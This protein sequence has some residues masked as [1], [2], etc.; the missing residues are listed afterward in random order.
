DDKLRHETLTVTA[1]AA[2][3]LREDFFQEAFAHA[4][5]GMAVTDLAGRFLQVNP[6]FCAI[7]GYSQAELLAAD[8]VAITH[9]DDR[10]GNLLLNRQLLAGDI[11]SFDL[12]KRYVKKNGATVWVLVSVS[13]RRDD[14][15]EPTHIIALCQDITSRKRAEEERDSLL[16]RKREP[17]PETAGITE[18]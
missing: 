1:T 12:E 2:S 11:S 7:T 3:R 16:V 6:A 4:A 5:V 10:A 15:G 9:P 8:F 17:C 14:Q 13:L 18:P